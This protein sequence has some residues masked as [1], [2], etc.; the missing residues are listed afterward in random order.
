MSVT[1]YPCSL[2]LP[3]LRFASQQINQTYIERNKV[4]MDNKR[5]SG[6][7]PPKDCWHADLLHGAQYSSFAE[8]PLFSQSTQIPDKVVAFNKVTPFCDGN[9]WLHFFVDDC[10]IEPVWENPEQ[11]LPCVQHF[12]GIISPDLSIYRDLPIPWQLFN[13]Y[14]NRALSY[15]FS[16]H[17][18]PV[19]P[20]IRWSDERSYSF[21]FDG[22][23]PNGVVCVSSH[24]VL[25]NSEDR[26]YFS[27]GLDEMMTRL[28]PSAVLVYGPMPP[29][30]FHK[31][32]GGG[33]RFVH[34]ESDVQRAHKRGQ[35]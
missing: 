2:Y 1:P 30:I 26:R 11:Y 32:R 14:R 5:F 28:A 23:E 7:R 24:G 15:W 25:S 12:S 35:E 22:I 6:R 8:L 3:F 9:Q 31:Y 19:I 27:N 17:G 21:C 10:R 13:T 4:I 34:F 18:V 29:D 16:S 33:T 20:N